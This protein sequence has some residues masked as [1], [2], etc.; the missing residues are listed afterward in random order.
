MDNLKHMSELARAPRAYD[1]IKCVE[2]KYLL[3][4]HRLKVFRLCAWDC[5]VIDR[6]FFLKASFVDQ[7]IV[8]RQIGR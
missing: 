6:K 5:L 1:L 7:W 2:F 4:R 8:S 3:A